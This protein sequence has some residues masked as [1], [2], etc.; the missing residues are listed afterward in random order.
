VYALEGIA[1]LPKPYCFIFTTVA[2]VIGAG[3]TAWFDIRMSGLVQPPG[4]AEILLYVF[5]I[6]LILNENYILIPNNNALLSDEQ[7][8]GGPEAIAACRAWGRAPYS[9]AAFVSADA[10]WHINGLPH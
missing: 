1:V 10:E 2:M 7:L 5:L 9:P 8:K 6:L 3:S 4:I